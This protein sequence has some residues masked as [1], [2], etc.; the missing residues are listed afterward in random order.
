T[1]YVETY[2]TSSFDSSCQRL[3]IHYF[4]TRRSSD[5]DFGGMIVAVIE[6]RADAARCRVVL[7]ELVAAHRVALDADA[8]HLALDG[9]DDPLLRSEE[10]T[11][12]LQSRFDLVC[13]LLLDT[14]KV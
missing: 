2:N 8:E 4:P 11:S 12:E 13:R 10:H 5:L 6:E 9:G 14:H 3:V 1:A 7:A